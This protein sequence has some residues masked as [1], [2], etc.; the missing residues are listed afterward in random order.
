MNQKMGPLITLPNVCLHHVPLCVC[1]QPMKIHVSEVTA[2]LLHGTDFIVEERGKVE[3]KVT[4]L[5][6]PS[7]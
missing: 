2:E 1:V 5:H 3:V 7:N 6:R 4:S